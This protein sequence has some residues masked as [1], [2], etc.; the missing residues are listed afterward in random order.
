MRQSIGSLFPIA[1][2]RSGPQK[3]WTPDRFLPRRKTAG[4][5]RHGHS[6]CAAPQAGR[7][8]GQA[9]RHVRQ[10]W[11]LLLLGVYG[12]AHGERPAQPSAV[13]RWLVELF[14]QRSGGAPG[15]GEAAG[16]AAAGR[17]VPRRAARGGRAKALGHARRVGIRGF[18]K[19]STVAVLGPTSWWETATM[20]HRLAFV[21]SSDPP[22]AYEWSVLDVRMVHTSTKTTVR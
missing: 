8:A 15:A 19:V 21:V 16:V 18:A 20:S 1:G 17:Q 14:L 12:R 10:R 5:A 4:R 7:I 9:F 11:Q 6:V 22:E 2:K 3:G 13:G